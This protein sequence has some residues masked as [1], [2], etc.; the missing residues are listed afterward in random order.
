MYNAIWKKIKELAPDLQ[1]N[2]QFIMSDYEA[3]AISSMN[4]NFPQSKIHG[5]WFHFNQVYLIFYVFNK[6]LHEYSIF[7]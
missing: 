5:C 3:A 1:K 2:L 6:L 4:N 7:T